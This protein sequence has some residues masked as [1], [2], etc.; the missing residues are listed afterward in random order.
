MAAVEVNVS[1]PMVQAS[2]RRWDNHS[3]QTFVRCISRSPPTLEYSLSLTGKRRRAVFMSLRGTSAA[4]SAALC[5]AD[6]ATT[7]V[8]ERRVYG[9]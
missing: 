8:A 4:L 9:P 7:T 2:I 1:A 3:G 5:R 6:T